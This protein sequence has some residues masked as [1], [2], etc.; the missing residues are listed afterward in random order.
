VRFVPTST[1][2]DGLPA[3]KESIMDFATLCSIPA[4][5]ALRPEWVAANAARPERVLSALGLPGFGRA[6]AR[7]ALARMAATGCSAHAAAL[8]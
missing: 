3:G 8:R 5:A 4:V 2:T 6:Y 7:Q 1:T